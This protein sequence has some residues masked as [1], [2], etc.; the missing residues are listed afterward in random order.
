MNYE[1][2]VNK[3][4]HFKLFYWILLI[5]ISLLCACGEGGGSDTEDESFHDSAY[6]LTPVHY[7]SPQARIPESVNHNCL[8]CHFG[9]QGEYDPHTP[10]VHSF[11]DH[12]TVDNKY[13][14]TCTNCHN[15]SGVDT[16]HDCH[17]LTD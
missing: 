9:D 7:D 8:E 3:S 5:A 6:G 11:D 10:W 16:C 4:V 2:A 12:W 1:I 17:V 15:T 14:Q 13:A